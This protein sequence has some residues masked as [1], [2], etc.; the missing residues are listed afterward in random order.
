MSQS[1]GEKLRQAR[2]ERGISVSEVAE[3]TRISPLYIKA[4]ENDDYKPLP[5]GIFNKGFVRSY[6]RYVG[7]DEEEALRDY[8]ELIGATG[9]QPEAE[10]TVH[11]SQVWTDDTTARSMAPTIIFAVI[12]LAMLVGGVLLLVR[13]ISNSGEPAI[14][15]NTNSAGNSQMNTNAANAETPAVPDAP[16]TTLSVGLKALSEPVWVAYTVDGNR[17]EKT[18]DAGQAVTLDAKENV[19]INYAKVK[20]ASLEVSINGRKLNIP[21]T[22]TKGS[23]DIDINRSNAQQLIASGIADTSATS[24]PKPAQTTTTPRPSPRPTILSTPN[25][26]RPANTAAPRRTP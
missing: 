26:A 21:T 9:I 6:A 2:E 14:V 22:S 18:L 8:A 11:R 12:I 23:F 7:F 19:K 4:I 20:A 17:I 10:Q 13:Y 15:R 25:P 3:Q 1:L 24:T 5:G 16:V